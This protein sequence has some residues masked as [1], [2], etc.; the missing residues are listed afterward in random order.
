M[1]SP[2]RQLPPNL[3]LRGKDLTAR[4]REIVQCIRI[5]LNNAEIAEQLEISINTVK[6]HIALIKLKIGA[7]NRAHIV[8]I[9][10]K[11]TQPLCAE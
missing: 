1:H 9:A 7:R 8:T 4:Q 10:V 6:A 5:G 2:L 3:A 11:E